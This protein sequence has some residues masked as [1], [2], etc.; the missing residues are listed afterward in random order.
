LLMFPMPLL[1]RRPI[2]ASTRRRPRGAMSDY[3]KHRTRRLVA[4]SSGHPA[5]SS[6]LIFLQRVD[7]TAETSCHWIRLQITRILMLFGKCWSA[8][9]DFG[10]IEYP[11]GTRS[12]GLTSADLPVREAHRSES[13]AL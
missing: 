8:Q 1:P 13:V 3:M 7:F 11:A 5:E 2:F 9:I 4:R 6:H 12:L 10:T